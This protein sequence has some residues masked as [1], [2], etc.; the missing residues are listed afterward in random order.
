MGQSLLNGYIGVPTG[1]TLYQ[2]SVMIYGYG[3]IGKALVQRLIAFQVKN[4]FI[5]YRQP[6]D[7]KSLVE[8]II[9]SSSPSSSSPTVNIQAGRAEEKFLEFA[10]QTDVVFLS[11][12]QNKDNIGL[13]DREFIAKLKK[14]AVIVNVSR[15]CTN[16]SRHIQTHTVYLFCIVIYLLSPNWSLNY[17]CGLYREVC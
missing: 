11:C 15:V 8:S 1:R 17:T 13:V 12:T 2:S 10:A 5:V 3:N 9:S 14:D 7:S 6:R 16:T 4:I